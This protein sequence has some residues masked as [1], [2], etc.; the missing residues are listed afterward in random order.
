MHAFG[1][2]DRIAN[3]RVE[4]ELGST[5]TGLL[6]QVVHL[7][8][9]RRAVI[10][11][12]HASVIG[13]RPFAVQL[14]REACLLEALQHPGVP[15]VYE[16]GL[17]PDRRPWFAVEMI[18]GGTLSEQIVNG[19]LT[20]IETTRLVRDTAEILEYAH[21]RGIIHRCLRPD[22]I[23]LTR[24][25]NFP[26]AI[27]SW[28]DARVHDADARVPHV[29]A[30]GAR[31]YV[32]PELARG[33][34]IDDRVDVFALGVIAY[35]ALTGAL[36][37]SSDLEHAGHIPTLE[38]RPDAPRELAQLI[39]QMLSHDRFDRPSSAEI[40]AEVDWL[41][42]VLGAP[43]CEDVE[44]ID[45]EDLPATTMRLRMRKPQWTPPYTDLS[46][47]QAA[48]ISGEIHSDRPK[49]R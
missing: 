31:Y 28:S 10:K 12:M 43:G 6:Y 39:D 30:P 48:T 9:P 44:L 11:V 13:L 5:S 1:P 16:S 26:V 22:G 45:E 38:R 14:L 19:P 18:E 27:P 20:V 3:Y 46:S 42:V 29:P 21:R 40:R 35:Q 2:G 36:P 47:Q 4:R 32:A 49:R 34:V 15:Q 37:R 8:L 33:D 7:V 41:A 23:V 25:R 17:L 24:G